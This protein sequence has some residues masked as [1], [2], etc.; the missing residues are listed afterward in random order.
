[1]F[2]QFQGVKTGH[3][4]RCGL[5]STEQ[6]TTTSLDMPA[7]HALIQP[8]CSWPP[9][10]LQRTAG[11]RPPRSPGPFQQSSPGRSITG[12]LPSQLQDFTLVLGEL[13][14]VHS[15]SL[16]RS[17]WIATM[18][19]NISTISRFWGCSGP[20]LSLRNAIFKELPA[21]STSFALQSHL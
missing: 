18:P 15:S 10:L 21:L 7:G 4:S 14:K 11:S 19:S 12:V 13:P 9:L 2:F 3:Y 20:C 17:V 8:T 1:M 6:K 16:S 5:T